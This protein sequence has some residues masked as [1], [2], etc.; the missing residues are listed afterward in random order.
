MG[1][2]LPLALLVSFI[3]GDARGLAFSWGASA[4]F[5]PALATI[6]QDLALPPTPSAP[7]TAMCTAGRGRISSI[8]ISHAQRLVWPVSC[9]SVF[10]RVEDGEVQKK[11]F[12]CLFVCFSCRY[13]KAA[14]PFSPPLD[15]RGFVI[16]N[17]VHHIW[18]E[19]PPVCMFVW[20]PQSQEKSGGWFRQIHT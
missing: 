9:L 18:I 7:A 4:C 13:K 17:E 2:N 8:P 6:A 15:H 1:I 20:A 12:V 5:M 3:R 11:L 14:T 16:D 10:K 19:V